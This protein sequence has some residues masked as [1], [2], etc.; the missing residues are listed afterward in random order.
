MWNLLREEYSRT[1]IKLST[2]E[3]RFGQEVTRELLCFKS[4]FSAVRV[5]VE[6]ADGFFNIFIDICVVGIF[7]V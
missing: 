7:R 4:G 1:T 5:R 2:I 6:C 3:E